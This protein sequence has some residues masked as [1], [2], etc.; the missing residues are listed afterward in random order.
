M[1][2]TT[3]TRIELSRE[4]SGTPSYQKFVNGK[5]A[6]VVREVPA[7]YCAGCGGKKPVGQSCDCFDNDC[8]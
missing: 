3:F 2:K 5:F 7:G 1:A 4:P 8:Q 6:G